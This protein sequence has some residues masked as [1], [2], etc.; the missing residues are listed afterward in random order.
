MHCVP[1]IAV[2]ELV[3]DSAQVGATVGQ[4]IPTRMPQG[5]RVNALLASVSC[6]DGGQVVH[7]LAGERLPALGD[8]QPPQLVLACGKVALDARNSSP[9]MGALPERVLQLHR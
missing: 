8:E 1:R 4:V 7:R 9:A 6:G 3:L 5:V 2:A